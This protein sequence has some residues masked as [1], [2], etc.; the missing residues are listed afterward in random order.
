VGIDCADTDAR[1]ATRHADQSVAT[2]FDRSKNQPRFDLR[3]RIDETDMGS[4]MHHAQFWRGEHHR[5]FFCVCQV[6][7][8]FRVARIPMSGKM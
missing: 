1:L 5:H 8:Q 6:G 2:A 3:D 7:N 4:H